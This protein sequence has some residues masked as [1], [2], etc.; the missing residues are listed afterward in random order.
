MKLVALEDLLARRS[1]TAA[2][3]WEWTGAQTRRYGTVRHGGRTMYVH[4]LSYQLHV[5]PVPDGMAVCHRCDNPPCFNP[6]HLFV[7]SQVEN[8]ADMKAKGRARNR[9]TRGEQH[10]RARLT[11]DQVLVIRERLCSG[12]SQAALARQYGVHKSTVQAISSRQAWRNVVAVASVACAVLLACG[13]ANAQ[14]GRVSDALLLA[15][16]AVSEAGWGAVETGDMATIHYA[17]LT[18]ADRDGTSWRSAARA[19]SPRATGTRPTAD[20]R[21]AWVSGLRED[22]LAPMRWPAPP[23]APWVTF[24]ARWLAV[25]E[26]AREVVTWNLE[27]HDEWSPCEERPITWAAR[28]H[29]PSPGLRPLD[30]GDTANLFY[31]GAR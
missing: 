7:A 16:V 19:L 14:Q 3:C 30:C 28:W 9:P 31:A 29:T 8:M 21:L 6:D 1:V 2:G 13:A 15:R 25:L 11:A 12:E 10:Y 23:H 26:R 24:R 22:L 18:V 5:G 17:Q 20:A 4:R 27:L